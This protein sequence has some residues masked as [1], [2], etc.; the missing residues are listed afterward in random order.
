MVA[1]HPACGLDYSAPCFGLPEDN[2][3]AEP[4]DIQTDPNHVGGNGDV[5]F[6]PFSLNASA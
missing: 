3:Q 4:R 6:F 2:H 1:A 5:D